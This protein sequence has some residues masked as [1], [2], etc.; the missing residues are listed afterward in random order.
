M[1]KIKIL[2]IFI[3]V[4]I[5][6]GFVWWQKRCTT[7]NI[8]NIIIYTL[9]CSLSGRQPLETPKDV[10]LIEPGL[11]YVEFNEGLDVEEFAQKYNIPFNKIKGPSQS[12]I[13]VVPVPKGQTALYAVTIFEEDPMVKSAKP[14]I[15]SH[16]F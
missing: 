4:I 13:Y 7:I 16:A 12:G 6:G 9:P 14:I 5:L 1:S 11:V 3:I 15:H 8:P 2:V 10:N